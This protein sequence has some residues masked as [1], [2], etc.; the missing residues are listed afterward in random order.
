MEHG[1]EL[2]VG[3]G[4]GEPETSNPEP[5]TK[6]SILELKLQTRTILCSPS[7]LT[8]TSNFLNLPNLLKLPNQF[9]VARESGRFSVAASGGVSCHFCLVTP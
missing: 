2:W 8:F 5:E 6:I 9:R 3:V 1:E 4:N 7:P